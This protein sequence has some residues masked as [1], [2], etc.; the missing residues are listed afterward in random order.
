MKKIVVNVIAIILA[1]ILLLVDIPYG[2]EFAFLLIGIVFTE[3][4]NFLIEFAGNLKMLFKILCNWNKY[5]RISFAYLFRIKVGNKYLLIMGN[6]IRKYQPVGGVYKFY[7][8]NYLQ[9]IGFNEMDE[10]KADG[11][12]DKDLRGK[13]P[14][15]KLPKLIKWFKSQECRE[16]DANR[17]FNEELIYS[18]I[19]DEKIFRNIEYKKVRTIESGIIKTSNYGL[20]YKIFDIVELI[21]NENQKRYLE[22]LLKN[23]INQKIAFVTE[24]EIK[25]HKRNGYNDN[26]TNDI[27]DHSESIL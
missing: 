13:I 22:E 20:E 15:N 21:P 12:N 17:E 5:I 3:F 2:A 26:Y 27:T 23:N 11:K 9:K 6:R 4:Y 14:A 16:Y 1:S 10:M 24:E 25:K 8:L 19:I 18:G 7:D